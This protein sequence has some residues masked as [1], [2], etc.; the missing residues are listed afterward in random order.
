MALSEL[1]KQR[2][3]FAIEKYLNPEYSLGKPYDVFNQSESRTQSDLNQIKGI[4]D[5]SDE[6]NIGPEVTE[7]LTGVEKGLENK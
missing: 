7:S 6:L 4:L 5:F 3:L 1:E 2:K